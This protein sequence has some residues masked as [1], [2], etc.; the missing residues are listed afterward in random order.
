[1]LY[2]GILEYVLWTAVEGSQL[3]TAHLTRCVTAL[4]QAVEEL[5][6]HDPA[7]HGLIMADACERW[8]EYRDNRNDRSRPRCRLR[9]TTLELLPSFIADAKRLAAVI[10]APTDG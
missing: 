9:G 7:K 4:E 8:L 3:D 5:G 10:G 2:D 1:M 6:R